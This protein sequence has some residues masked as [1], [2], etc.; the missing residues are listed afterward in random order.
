VSV[1]FSLPGMDD[2]VAPD[3][4]IYRLVPT[5][6]CDPVAGEWRF[7]SAAFD[8]SSLAGF[9]NEMSVVLGDTLGALE[10]DPS[11]LPERA[12]PG[13]PDWGV[14]V[15]AAGCITQVPEQTLHRTPTEAEPAHG[16]GRGSKNSGRRKRLK[17]C[18]EWVIPPASPAH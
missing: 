9:E 14:A 16:D 11:D 17:K 6:Q 2:D 7:R 4:R 3:T 15:M 12:Y 8:N 18:A 5:N 10:R 13:N 1:P